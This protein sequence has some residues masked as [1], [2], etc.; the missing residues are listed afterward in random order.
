MAV[1][2]VGRG[3]VASARVKMT[4]TKGGGEETSGRVRV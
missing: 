1:L 3:V 2:P 4:D